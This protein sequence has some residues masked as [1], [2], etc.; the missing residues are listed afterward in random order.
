MKY[1]NDDMYLSTNKQL[2]GHVQGNEVDRIKNQKK[3]TR[4]LSHLN[5]AY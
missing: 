1:R 2:L 4:K 5:E 3:N